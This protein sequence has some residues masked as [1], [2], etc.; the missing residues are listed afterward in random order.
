MRVRTGGDVVDMRA[1]WWE[2]EAVKAIDQRALPHDLEIA[3]IRTHTE[4]ASAISNMTIRGAPSIGAAGAYGMALAWRNELDLK[5][6]AQALRATRPTAY[7]LFHAIDL[8]SSEDGD[9]RRAADRYADS[10]VSRCELIGKNGSEL[11]EDGM[12]I[13]THCNAGALA[14]VDFGTALAPM[15]I[16]HRAGR[17]I[18]VFV[19][20]TRPRLQGAKLTAWELANEGIEHAVIADNAAGHYLRDEVDMVIVGADRIA[21]NGDFA[22]KIGTYEKAV[23]ASENEVPFYVAAPLSTFD[24]ALPSGE[25]IVIEQRSPDE[26]LFIDEVRVAAGGSNALNPAFDVTPSKFVTGFITEQGIFRADSLKNFLKRA[27]A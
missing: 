15:R 26:V 1:L 24:S 22:N 21:A 14:T 8:M 6:A 5:D 2:D 19:D 16:A 9:L 13:L 11:V 4:M 18:F 20:E 25:G 10:V 12:K 17:R 7:D 23:V 3:T 27:R